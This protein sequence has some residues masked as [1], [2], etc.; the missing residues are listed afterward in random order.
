M[1][2]HFVLPEIFLKA[3]CRSVVYTVLLLAASVLVAASRDEDS[4]ADPNCWKAAPTPTTYVTGPAQSANEGLATEYST[5]NFVF[6]SGTAIWVVDATVPNASMVIRSRYDIIPPEWKAR[7]YHHVGDSDVY[8]NYTVNKSTPVEV[9]FLPLSNWPDLGVPP[10]VIGYDLATLQPNGFGC[11]LPG[12]QYRYQLDSP[13]LAVQGDFIYATSFYMAIELYVYSIPSC[14]LHHTV[15]LLP[16]GVLGMQ[17]ATLFSPKSLVPR[18]DRYL[19]LGSGD[20]NIYA[21]DTVTGNTTKVISHKL[22]FEM[23]GLA[24]RD[25][26]RQGMGVVH[27][28]VGDS[29]LPWGSPRPVHHYDYVC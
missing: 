13:W 19:L 26:R 6:N 10:A 16:W 14:K 11:I 24:V 4:V 2:F 28:L 21:M 1:S 18:E 25:L 8:L 20:C 12:E 22:N 29:L 5:G 23:E 17:G 3:M 27:V 7:N 9:L 15:R